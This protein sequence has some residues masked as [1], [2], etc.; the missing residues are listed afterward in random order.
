MKRQVKDWE[1][2]A[3]KYNR[4]NLR[5]WS[6]Q[7]FY[8]SSTNRRKWVQETNP[9]AGVRKTAGRRA[10]VG[11]GDQRRENQRRKEMHVFGQP[12][13]R[14]GWGNRKM[15]PRCVLMA[16]LGW[17]DLSGRLFGNICGYRNCAS[18]QQCPVGLYSCLGAWSV[19]AKYSTP[20]C[21]YR[22]TI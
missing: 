1:K 6:S 22:V 21:L 9:R 16:S 8:E 18:L 14:T 13:G 20:H 19:Y 2:N 17:W 5:P 11:G 10:S 15:D 12:S 4:I 3:I 7:S